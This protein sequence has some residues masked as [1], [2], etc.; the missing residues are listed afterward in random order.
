VT[1][2]S[3]PNGYGLGLG[4]ETTGNGTVWYYEGQTFGHRVLHVCFPTTG[5]II[6][7]AVDSSTDNDQLTALARSVY[8]ILQKAGDL[9]R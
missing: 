6:A 5:L 7:L 3:D 1:T 8:Q 4:Q 9:T 2:L